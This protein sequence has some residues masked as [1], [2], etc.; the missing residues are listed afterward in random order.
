MAYTVNEGCPGDDE[1][2]GDGELFQVVF[3]DGVKIEG[4]GR[5][6]S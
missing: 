1:I 6:G 5:A 3:G 2:D 4:F